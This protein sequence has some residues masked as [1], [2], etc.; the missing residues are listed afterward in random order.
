MPN[1]CCCI[2]PLRGGVITIGLLMAAASVALLIATFVHKNPM[3]IH[4]EVVNPVLPWVY[5]AVTGIYTAF[6][7][8]VGKLP[9]M[10][11]DKLLYWL[12]FAIV[13]VWQA[14]SFV[15]AIVN[16]SRST[17][18]CEQANPSGNAT[19]SGNSTAQGFLG[20]SIGDTYGLANCSQA[21]EVGLI[22][23][24]VLL[25]VG[26]LFMI[27]FGTV[28]SSY[29]RRLRERQLGHRL[30]DHSDWDESVMDLTNA[31]REDARNAP[32]YQ[33]QPINQ[34]KNKFKFPKLKF[35][36]N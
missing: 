31:Y 35:G 9:L 7:S 25:F 22:A 6:A 16:R 18:A 19:T 15:L 5:I 36:R 34:K 27:Y 29:C 33:M 23:I 8:V 13:T 24:A 14:V 4:L 10:K 20:V 30:R 17:D 32:R 1:K 26:T 11:L 2:I 3:I 21:V 28:I 12:F